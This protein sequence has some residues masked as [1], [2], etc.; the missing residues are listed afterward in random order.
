LPGID[1]DS[2]A[3]NLFRHLWRLGTPAA[4]DGGDL[5]SPF[6]LVITPIP[7]ARERERKQL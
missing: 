3:K 1:R 4:N 5:L 2:H 6:M 7:N